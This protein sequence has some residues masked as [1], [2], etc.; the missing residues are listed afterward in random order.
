MS[1]K[2]LVSLVGGQ[3]IPNVLF[4]QEM[5]RADIYVFI[6]S[7]QTVKLRKQIENACENLIKEKV[8]IEVDEYSLKSFNSAISNQFEFL[9]DDK[10][11]VNITGGTKIMSLGTYDYFL[12]KFPENSTVFYCDGGKNQYRQIHPPIHDNIEKHSYKIPLSTYLKANGVAKTPSL[13]FEEKE[14]MGKNKPLKS[15]EY[16]TCLYDIFS[17]SSNQ[18][19]IFQMKKLHQNEARGKKVN[20]NEKPEYQELFNQL[21]ITNFDFEDDTRQTLSKYETK[22]LTGDWFEEYTYYHIKP[23]LDLPVNRIVLGLNS[24]RENAPNEYDILFTH[25]NDLYYIECKSTLLDFTGKTNN[26]IF[27]E[28]LYKAAANRNEFGTYTKCYLF[29]SDDFS[30]LTDTQKGRAE[31]LRIKLVGSEILSKEDGLKKLFNIA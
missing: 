8:Y 11:I 22:Y 13:Y 16:S 19:L 30:N 23:L 1:R 14:I 20:L 18:E 24:T 15:L 21:I 2:I 27:N 31:I 6:H 26:F 17:S 5:E 12:Q 25:D 3:T 7:K 10:I 28:A 9:K 29:C 4:I